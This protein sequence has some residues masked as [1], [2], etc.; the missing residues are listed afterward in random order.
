MMKFAAGAL[1][2]ILALLTG[3]AQ[4]DVLEFDL[5]S[6]FLSDQMGGG[7]CCH[8]ASGTFKFDTV[9]ESVFDVTVTSLYGNYTFGAFDPGFQ[10]YGLF[11]DTY[12]PGGT[13]LLVFDFTVDYGQLLADV[14]LAGVGD[15]VFVNHYLSIQVY[16][17]GGPGYFEGDVDSS[18]YATVL[19]KGA[20]TVPLP[21]TL[22]LILAGFGGLA[23][24]RRR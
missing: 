19:S 16:E 20:P 18:I 14:A 2:G 21:A 13:P 3:P 10:A 8:Q 9:T 23:L 12:F 22:P 15:S 11:D 6:T 17:N 5:N 1:F 4:A 7:G 24:L